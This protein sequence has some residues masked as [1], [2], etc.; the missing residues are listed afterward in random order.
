MKKFTLLL[1]AGTVLL[2]CRKKEVN[3]IDG[4]DLVDIYGT[5]EVVTP[6]PLV[7]QLLI[8][9]LDNRCISHVKHLQ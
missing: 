5:F 6:L 8:S 7:N 4:P 2:A 1:I 9:V 3:K